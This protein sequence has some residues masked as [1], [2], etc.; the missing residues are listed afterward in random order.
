MQEDQNKNH[1]ETNQDH[2]DFGLPEANY[3]PIE[4][5]EET[6]PA[7]EPPTYYAEEEQEE[8]PKRGWIITGVIGFFLLI[9]IAVYLFLFDGIDQIGGLFK[10]EPAPPVVT[11][12]PIEKTPEPEPIIEEPVVEAPVESNPVNEL[13]P[14]EGMTTISAPTGRSYVVIASFVDEDM[15]NDFGQKMLDKGIGVKIIKPTSR[16][17]L[18]HRVAVADYQNFGEAMQ[19][20]DRFRTEYGEKAWVL[21]F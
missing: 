4:R 19:L 18:N 12:A 2:D 11:E 8:E 1:H 7:F 13:A 10:E 3:D 15:A 17:P 20:I 6:P 16:S 14:Y 5:E 9:G 21:K